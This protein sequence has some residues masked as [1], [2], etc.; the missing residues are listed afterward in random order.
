MT[1]C[2]GPAPI[3]A[4]D[5]RSSA[6]IALPSQSALL[7]IMSRIGKTGRRAMDTY[8]IARAV[9]RFILAAFFI[10]AGIAHLAAPAEL[11][12]ITPDWVPFAPQ[13]IFVTG[14][15]EIAGA[16]ALVLGDIWQ[17]VF[18][19]DRR[20]LLYILR[21]CAGIALAAYAVCVWPANF[22]HAF[23]GIDIAHVPS[24][25]WYHAPR[26]VLQPVIVWAALFCSGVIDWPWHSPQ[27]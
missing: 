22:K 15:C 27:R 6:A 16:T 24:S 4:Q 14:L 18:P 26:L 5:V 19:E 17:A 13:V 8:P 7:F 12:K 21:Q 3:A 20:L 23:D 10:A 1:M 25:W 2:T 11:L 9:M